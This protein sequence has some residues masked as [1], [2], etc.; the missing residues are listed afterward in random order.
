MDKKDLI[1]YLKSEKFSDKIINA[2]D[3]VNREDFISDE[4]KEYAYEN[5]PIPLMK[6]A[7][8]S[9]PYT[10]AFM[11]DL[12]ELK[13]NLKIL[14]VGS[15]SGYVLSLINQISKGS[16]IYGVE[17]ISELV[18]KSTKV[19]KEDKNIEI[20]KGD[21]NKGLKKYALYDRILVSA[22]ANE[23]PLYLVDQLKENGI[24]VCPVQNSI[25]KINKVNGKMSKE[26]FPGFIF[27]PLKKV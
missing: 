6:N 22:S 23:M 16:N 5:E 24:L 3:K 2:F 4:Y 1:N 17:I 25:W 7:T 19:L 20:I 21:G 9:Q 18:E 26:E 11:L 27:V 13:N 10:I 8:V 14:E 12:L 15:G